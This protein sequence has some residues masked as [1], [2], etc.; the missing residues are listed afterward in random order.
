[1]FPRAGILTDAPQYRIRG[2]FGAKLIGWRRNTPQNIV[3][4]AM[5]MPLELNNRQASSCGAG[6]AKG[7]A[8][9]DVKREFDSRYGR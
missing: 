8:W 5:I 2:I 6:N 1:M 9:D 7:R 4:P 3:E